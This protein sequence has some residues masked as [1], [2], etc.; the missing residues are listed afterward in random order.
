MDFFKEKISSHSHFWKETIQLILIA[1]IVVIPFRLYV[2]QPFVVDGSSMDPTF[3]DGQYLIV[4]ELSYH[5][6]KPE[7]GAVV[8]LRDVHSTDLSLSAR[9]GKLIKRESYP[10]VRYLIKR[11]IGL[12]EEEIQI[13]GGK[14]TIF[15]TDHPEGLELNEPYIKFP[16]NTSGTYKLASDEYFVMGDN[17]ANSS[18][19]RSWGPLPEKNITG[20]PI[21]RALPMTFF[22]GV[23][24][25]YQDQE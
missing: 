11:V 3:G 17:R 24:E 16:Q 7:R 1:V 18:D 14:V 25:N 2:A 12:P 15:N 22:P 19:S 13:T 9:I 6:T 10:S 23:F 4:D 21:W 20:R 8:V 5:F